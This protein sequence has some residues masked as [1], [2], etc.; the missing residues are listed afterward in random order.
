[1]NKNSAE[2]EKEKIKDNP[3]DETKKNHIG[4]P[5]LILKKILKK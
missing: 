3:I 1:M 2:K 4:Y 5:M